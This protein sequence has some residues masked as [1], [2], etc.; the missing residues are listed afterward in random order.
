[1][2]Y[3]Y[4]QPDI[5]TKR[6]AICKRFYIS[7]KW[8]FRQFQIAIRYL[9]IKKMTEIVLVS[10]FYKNIKKKTWWKKI[11]ILRIFEFVMKHVFFVY[12]RFSFACKTESSR[13]IK[14]I[15]FDQIQGILPFFGYLEM[16][17]YWA[18]LHLL[19]RAV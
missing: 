15:L 12:L 5:K 2:H 8:L 18:D 17:I 3:P 6:F 11:T 9:Q 7:M 19:M 1:M 13:K 4:Q 10:I 16:S 14:H